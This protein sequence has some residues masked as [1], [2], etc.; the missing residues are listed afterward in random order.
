[1]IYFLLNR[2]K[3]ILVFLAVFSV[4]ESLFAILAILPGRPEI[5]LVSSP[6]FFIAYSPILG[7]AGW[8]AIGLFVSQ[9]RM[10]NRWQIRKQ[11][12]QKGLDED[13]Y[14]LMIKMRGR[15]SRLT[16][17]QNMESPKHRFEL[18]DLTGIDWKEVDRELNILQKYGL[19]MEY[20]HSGTVKLYKTTEQGRLLMDLVEEL[21]IRPR[22]QEKRMP[23]L[24]H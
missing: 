9:E 14:D 17:L 1:M 21:D 6:N 24:S 5:L 19:I 3:L 11:F 7:A 12:A 23:E 10:S 22:S 8:I 15:T 18:S 2:R 20:A 4:A 16:L 13:T